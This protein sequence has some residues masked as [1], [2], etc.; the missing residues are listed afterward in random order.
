MNVIDLVEFGDSKQTQLLEKSS[1]PALETKS[2]PPMLTLTLP[3][4]GAR[5]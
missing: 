2:I 1:R 3:L 5:R 4:M